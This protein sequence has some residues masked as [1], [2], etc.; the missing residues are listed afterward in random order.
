MGSRLRLGQTYPVGQ[1]RLNQHRV[2][3]NRA[4]GDDAVIARQVQVAMS[5]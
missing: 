2:D 1:P 3:E 5:R 4:P